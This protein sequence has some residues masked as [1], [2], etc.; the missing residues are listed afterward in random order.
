MASD[1]PRPTQLVAA[2]YRWQYRQEESPSEIGESREPRVG[3]FV[4]AFATCAEHIVAERY[5]RA[6]PSQSS[7]TPAMLLPNLPVSFAACVL[8]LSSAEAFQRRDVKAFRP[9]QVAAPASDLIDGTLRL[10]APSA[11]AVRSRGAFFQLAWNPDGLGGWWAETTVATAPGP[12][13][14][15]VQAADASAFDIQVEAAGI[16]DPLAAS[17]AERRDQVLPVEL[18]AEEVQRWDL[19]QVNGGPIRV[20]VHSKGARRPAPGVLAV[21]DSQKLTAAAF[22]STH[23]R[24]SNRAFALVAQVERDGDGLA[25]ERLVYAV[26][27]A[28]ARVEGP[29]YSNTL[30]LADDGQSGDGEAGDGRFGVRLPLGLSGAYSAR[31]ELVGSWD[32]APFERTTRVTFDVAEPLLSLT[33]LVG[34]KVLDAR[35]LRLDID[36]LPLAD[37]RRVQVSAEV[38]AHDEWGNPQPMAWLSRIDEPR[39]HSRGTWS[40]PLWLDAGWF[41]ATGL[42]PPLELRRVRVQDAEHFGVLAQSERM[43]VP[44]GPLPPLAGR[45][46]AKLADLFG[47]TVNAAASVATPVAPAINIQPMVP[48]PGLVLS[49]GYCSSGPV[50]PQADFSQPKLNFADPSQNRSHDEFANLIVAQAAAYTSFG[51]VGHSQG[52]AAALHLLTFYQS[53][54]DRARGPRRIQSVGTPYQGTPLAS[55]GFF[56]CGVNS[57]MTPGGAATWLAGIPNWARSEVSYYTTANDGFACQFLTDLLLSNPEDGTTERSRGQLPGGQNMGHVTGWCHTSGMSDPA[58]STDGSRNVVLNAEAAR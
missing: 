55:L 2:M 21:R 46:G 57:N 3:R 31:I 25:E 11:G 9:R 43:V 13:S 7:L 30:S 14:L 4:G 15:A 36:A 12:I 18:G 41:A 34:T 50:W 27:T 42:R 39:I 38:W 35:R 45:T 32:G 48:N 10:P 33:G 1:S 56:A 47:V 40:L 37:A 23:E 22:V 8:L 52:G 19:A 28:V 24:L 16:E 44:A 17:Q 51:F 49:H 6:S 20:I 54:L 53:P 29:G 58:Q 26:S 5:T